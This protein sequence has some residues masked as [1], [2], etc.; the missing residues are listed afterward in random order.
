MFRAV[1]LLS[2]NQMMCQA[3]ESDTIRLIQVG[4][5]R[6]YERKNEDF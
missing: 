3:G 1:G 2:G 4:I 5:W 6:R